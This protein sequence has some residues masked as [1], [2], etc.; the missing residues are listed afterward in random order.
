MHAIASLI[1]MAVLRY[2]L[3]PA[4][5]LAIF[6]GPGQVDSRFVPRY[7]TTPG[8][9]LRR[10]V[11]VPSGKVIVFGERGAPVRLNFDGTVDGSFRTVISPYFRV[12]EMVASS[13]KLYFVAISSDQARLWRCLP[14]GA[15]DGTFSS[16]SFTAIPPYSVEILSL[17]P[18]LDGGCIVAGHFRTTFGESVTN[19]ARFKADG[20]F[21]N[22]F[23]TNLSASRLGGWPYVIK[24][25]WNGQFIVSRETSGF[26]AVSK[27]NENGSIDPTFQAV[28]SHSIG[29]CNYPRI[30][31][32][33]VLLPDLKLL[34]AGSC[35]IYRPYLY[36]TSQACGAV[37]R[38]MPDGS[39]DSSFKA[40]TNLLNVASV[41]LQ[42]DGKIVVAGAKYSPQFFRLLPNGEYDPAFAPLQFEPKR[43]WFRTAPDN[44]YLEP[45]PTVVYD[46]AIDPWDD[47]T[48]VGQFT[49]VNGSAR[50]FAARLLGGAADSEVRLRTSSF[51]ADRFAFS[52]FGPSNYIAQVQSSDCLPARDWM[53]YTNIIMSATN[54]VVAP[55]TDSNRFFRVNLSRP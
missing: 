45:P 39:L 8:Y 35:S 28:F 14:N 34:V 17:A 52:V 9:E 31:T 50:Q 24:Q 16:V 33:F 48:I 7:E 38:L 41:A 49:S 51:D 3:V 22:A 11:V 25:L 1:K 47:V 42:S 5:A 19:I 23:A 55:I 53:A 29:W 18:T 12:K 32:E 13:D 15:E 40:D 46:L 37:T 26:C 36:A 4:L 20:T 21:D 10:V 44:C 6:A 43:T 2:L 27:L 54:V 30:M